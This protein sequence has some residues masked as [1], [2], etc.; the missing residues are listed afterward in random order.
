M[1][2][3]MK[4]A[5]KLPSVIAMF[6]FAANVLADNT[7]SNQNNLTQVQG[8]PAA[9]QGQSNGGN[10]NWNPVSTYKSGSSNWLMVPSANAVR[11]GECAG[12]A[13]GFSAGAVLA[14]LGFS[15][16]DEDEACMMLKAIE[17]T[18]AI[19]NTYVQTGFVMSANGS[20]PNR[21]STLVSDNGL[22]LI[23]VCAQGL[24]GNPYVVQALENFNQTHRAGMTGR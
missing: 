9:Y 2:I 16:S 12:K 7:S 20:N 1:I 6:L 23:Q 18:C 5:L 8:G 13:Y 11:N 17:A 4:K 22:T 15:F 10:V 24:Q 21:A 19:G 14:A 3:D